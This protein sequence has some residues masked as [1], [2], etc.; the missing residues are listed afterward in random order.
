MA[1]TVSPV[2]SKLVK[3][4]KG[5]FTLRTSIAG[6]NIR[7]NIYYCAPRRPSDDIKVLIV[8][9][10]T[11]RDADSYRD[12]WEKYAQNE[13][14]LVLVP[15]FSDRNF[16]ES[17]SYNLA[18]MIDGNGN[19]TKKDQ[20]A[21]SLIDKLFEEVKKDLEFDSERF[22]LYGHSAGAQFV[23]RYVMFHPSDKLGLAIAANSGWYSFPKGE[24][25]F[26]YTIGNHV[27]SFDLRSAFSTN[28][29]ILLGSEDTDPNHKYLR[30]SKGAMLQGAHRLERG[31]NYYR[32]AKEVCKANGYNF[33]WN[34]KVVS[35]VAHSNS[36]M[37]KAAIKVILNTEI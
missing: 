12:S 28:L 30:K 26:P 1:F 2:Y 27:K 7:Q 19:T 23:H 31:Q 3:G 18:G 11:K 14:L 22:Y 10:G 8:M 5:D 9:H 20:W 6:K 25:E 34:L 33:N 13:N 24:N 15:E 17:I 4:T 29:T 36:G 32:S 16:P 35:G 21:F 37:S